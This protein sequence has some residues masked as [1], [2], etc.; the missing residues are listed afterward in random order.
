[1]GVRVEIRGDK[2]AGMGCGVVVRKNGF[3]KKL[4]INRLK[5]IVNI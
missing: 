5:E 4:G 3:C 2:G 1:M